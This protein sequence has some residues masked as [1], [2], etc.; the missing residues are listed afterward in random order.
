[1]GPGNGPYPEVVT[2]DSSDDASALTPGDE[3]DFDPPGP[4]WLYRLRQRWIG[5]SALRRVVWRVVVTV[6]GGA[7]ILAGLAMLVLPGPGWAAIFL[8]LAVLATEYAW[9]HR[10][11]VTTKEK[12]Q[13]AASSA[14]SPEN[15]RRTFV[16]IVIAAMLVASLVSW[17]VYDFG[18]TF[19]GPRRWF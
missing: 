16:L 14:F 1:V 6:L 2:A 3:P 10:L 5:D 18:W 11:L 8:G 13:G 7:I 17:Y 15:R 9:A 12:A 4:D 19:D